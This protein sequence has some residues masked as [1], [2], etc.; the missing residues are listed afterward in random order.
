MTIITLR[1]VESNEEV[2]VRSVID[3]VAKLDK[4][5]EVQI[6]PIKKWMFDETGDFVQE[7][8]YE[9]L[10]NGKVGMYVSLQY[11]IIKIETN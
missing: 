2:I 4:N 8:L 9:S 5:E 7:D 6:I 3:P 11:V 10:E 1:D